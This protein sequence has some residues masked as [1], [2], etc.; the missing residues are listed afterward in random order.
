MSDGRRGRCRGCNNDGHH[1][2]RGCYVSYEIAAVATA[3][4]ATAVKT[5]K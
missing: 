4:N 5:D 3:A 1:G 2:D